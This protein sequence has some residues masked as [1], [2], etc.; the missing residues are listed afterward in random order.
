MPRPIWS[1][2]ISFGLL[3]IPI[4]L[5][6]GER[7][8]DLHFRLLDRRDRKPIRYERVNA[9]TGEEVPWKDIVKAFQYSK[10]NYVVV[11]P[12]EIKQ[13]APEATQTI[14][15]E[16][17]VDADSI[18]PMYFDK[19]Y[20]LVPAKRAEKGYVLLREALRDSRKLGI[21]RVVIRTRQYLAALLA[22]GDALVLDLLRFPQEIV[23]ASDLDLPERGE[24]KYAP[25]PRELEMASALLESM[26]TEWKPADYKD[27]FRDKLRKLL[28]AR[29][30]KHEGTVHE[31]PAQH[32]A[33]QGSNVV[34][35]MALLKKSLDRKAPAKPTKAAAKKTPRAR[36]RPRTRR[37]GKRA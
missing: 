28:E 15:I 36:A 21:A 13:A 31:T 6:S 35:F 32:E 9:E 30:R 19:P 25:K 29:A 11:D 24:K 17:F 1:G 8:V 5:H 22:Q 23:D 4:T 33:P 16:S 3:Q 20:Y 37:T 34:D 7:S 10:G 12:D 26:A 14:E 18:D 2:T 27:E